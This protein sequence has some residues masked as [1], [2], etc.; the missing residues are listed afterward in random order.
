M[1]IR[2][3]GEGESVAHAFVQCGRLAQMHLLLE[4]QC[5]RFECHAHSGQHRALFSPLLFV[6]P[7]PVQQ[8]LPTCQLHL[9]GC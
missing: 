1:V 3:C 5:G 8:E 2:P 4:E 7:P 9:K 6:W